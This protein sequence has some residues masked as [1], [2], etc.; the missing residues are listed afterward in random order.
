MRILVKKSRVEGRVRVPSSK[1]YTLRALMCAAMAEGKSKLLNPLSS[2][3]TDAAL[4]VLNKIGVAVGVRKDYWLVNGGTFKQPY[5][6]LFCGDSAATLRFMSAICTTLPGKF[7]LTAGESLSKRPVDDLVEALI[8]WGASIS[9]KGTVAP[10]MINGDG[11]RGGRT[12]LPGD[13]SSQY[14]SALLLAAPRAEKACTIWLTTPLE[15]RPYIEM[16]L[17]CLRKFGIDIRHTSEMMEFECFPQK[18]IPTDYPV[19]GDW[20]SASYLLGLGAVA[21]EIEAGNLKLSSLQGDKNIMVLL[22]AMG[23]SIESG[24]DLLCV[25]S[26]SLAP[27]AA[28]LSDCIDLLPTMAVLAALAPGKSSFSGIKRARLKES[29]RIAAVKEGLEKSG[30]EVEEEEDRIII[31]GGKPHSAVIDTKNDHRIA[32]AFSL[33]G[34]AAGGITIEGAEC[35]SKTYPEFW[36][37]LRGLGVKIDEQ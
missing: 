1:S 7:K 12:E 15:S 26:G 20:S 28:N 2:D 16:T 37:V 27:L 29:N 36:K 21:G 13:I 24:G 31:N 11:L 34:A 17:E 25:R 32:M 3:D 6:D 9:C 4:R 8:M 18:F 35:V 30:I 22:K 10:V 23:A 33:M 14:I 5:E 19:E